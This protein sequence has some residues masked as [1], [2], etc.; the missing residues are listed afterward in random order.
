MKKTNRREERQSNFGATSA[1]LGLTILM[2]L[3]AQ[4]SLASLAQDAHAD[5]KAASAR[6][7]KKF[8]GRS[9][10]LI[11]SGNNRKLS[12]GSSCFPAAKVSWEAVLQPMSILTKTA[13]PRCMSM[14]LCRIIPPLLAGTTLI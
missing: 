13:A 12:A 8:P 9:R 7:R 6:L 3:I 1:P 14:N 11:W 2:A 5:G 4:G 10:Q